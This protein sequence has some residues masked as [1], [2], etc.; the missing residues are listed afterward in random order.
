MISDSIKATLGSLGVII[1][2]CMWDEETA[3][4]HK[5]NRDKT[6]HTSVIKKKKKNYFCLL[7]FVNC[8]VILKKC[9]SILDNTKYPRRLICKLPK[10]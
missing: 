3:R 1:I 2:Q 10:C 9:Y 4:F 8:K 5:I 7:S 6:L